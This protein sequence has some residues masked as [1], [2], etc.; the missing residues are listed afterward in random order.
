MTAL[1]FDA[2]LQAINGRFGIHDIAC[3]LCGPEK[4]SPSNRIRRVLRLW[5]VSPGFISFVCARCGEEGFVRDRDAPR[6]NPVTRARVASELEQH[7]QA[8][9][10]E[11]L[12]KALA[13]WRIRQPLRGTIAETYLREARAYNGALPPTLGF[14]PARDEYLPAMI[15]AFGIPDEPEPGLLV[16]PDAKLKGVHLTRLAVDGS[17]RDCGQKAKIMIG[18]SSGA[19]I[20]LAPP[21]DLLGLVIS[22]GI[23]DGLSAHVATGLGSWVA[24][25]AG[26]LP[27]I[28]GAIPHYVEAITVLV[29]DDEVGRRH[30][31][32]LARRLSARGVDFRLISPGN[33]F[34]RTTK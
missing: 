5:Y 21:N 7:R 27:A 28:C 13:L 3:P 23:E 9:A 25:S 32:E 33:S 15:A 26:R 16:L 31:N 17:D 34:S 11:R 14:L 6:I 29:D 12:R 2:L 10:A 18:M 8:G 4:R 24:G 19:P 1:A 30:A 22:E 20:V